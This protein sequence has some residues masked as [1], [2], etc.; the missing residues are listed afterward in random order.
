MN[1]LRRRCAARKS[2]PSQDASP[3][4]SHTKSTIL[5]KQSP[6]CSTS[7][8][9]T[10]RGKNCR[11][12][13][14]EAEREL[15]RVTEITT[16]TLRFYREPNK[17]TETELA[18]VLQSVLVL[19]QSRLTAANIS[20]EQDIREP[21]LTVLSSP[22]ELRQVIANIIGNS[23]DAMRR[24]GRLRIRISREKAAHGA[25]AVRLTIADTGSGNSRPFAAQNIRTL[26]HH[27]RRDRHGTGLVGNRG[28]RQKEWMEDPGPQQSASRVFRNNILSVHAASRITP[29]AADTR[30]NIA[31]RWQRTTPFDDRKLQSP[32]STAT[33][34]AQDPAR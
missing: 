28:D 11:R 20:V 9:Q 24:G 15:A 5:W 25:S 4:A 31:L 18:S 34:T 6:I 22:G 2:S 7:C 30:E 14:E 3:Q 8:G 19:Y 10:L 16:Q 26:H 21:F 12:Y 1:V 17:P 23:I 32:F 13:L 33:A 29:P 27:Q